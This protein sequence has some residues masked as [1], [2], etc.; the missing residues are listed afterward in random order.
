LGVNVFG[1]ELHDDWGE[2]SAFATGFDKGG[3]LGVVP[4]SPAN[5]CLDSKSLI[6][7]SFDEVPFLVCR[8]QGLEF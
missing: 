2:G 1:K 7:V 4:A 8:R 6:C 5:P 3:K